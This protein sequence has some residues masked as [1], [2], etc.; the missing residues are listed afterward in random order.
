MGDGGYRL[1]GAAAA[2]APAPA[3]QQPSDRRTTHRTEAAPRPWP[4]AADRWPSAGGRPPFASSRLRLPKAAAT[5]HEPRDTKLAICFAQRSFAGAAEGEKGTGCSPRAKTQGREGN[6]RNEDNKKR[7]GKLPLATTAA[8]MAMMAAALSNLAQAWA[9]PTRRGVR[10]G[11]SACTCGLS[12]GAL[13]ASGGTWRR[14]DRLIMSILRT[15]HIQCSSC[16]FHYPA[17]RE[18]PPHT[19]SS[20][21]TRTESTPLIALHEARIQ[22]ARDQAVVVDRTAKG[23]G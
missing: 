15:R 4:P 12:T 16:P 23:S 10:G 5:H 11:T 19:D 14:E 3:G 22:D 20:A 1:A 7:T 2:S 21:P 13:L 18:R 8:I 6:Q 17:C 9:E